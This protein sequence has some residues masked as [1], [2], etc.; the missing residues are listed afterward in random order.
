MQSTSP[1]VQQV[2]H[3]TLDIGSFASIASRTAS[4]IWSQILSGCPSV[5][6]SDVKRYLDIKPFLS[7]SFKNAQKSTR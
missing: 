1:V 7:F 4:E 2:S 5:T 3:A 6:D